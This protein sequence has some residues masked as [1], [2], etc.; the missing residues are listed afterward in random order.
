LSQKVQKWPLCHSNVTLLCHTAPPT[1][2]SS[3][4]LITHSFNRTRKEAE[5]E[6][7]KIKASMQNGT[8]RDTKSAENHTLS[9]AI[10]RFLG[11]SFTQERKNLKTEQGHLTWWKEALGDY[12]LIRL[13]PELIAKKRDELLTDFTFKGTQRSPSTSTGM[14]K[15]EILSLKWNDINL[16]TSRV[17][18]KE[19]LDSKKDA[20]RRRT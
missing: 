7:I 16:Q 11:E 2:T 15:G 10:D 18:G 1:P 12:A 4:K 5:R 17:L 6:E 14:R 13:T 19:K 8:F 9:D 3:N 20:F